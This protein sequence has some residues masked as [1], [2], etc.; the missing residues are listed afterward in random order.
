MNGTYTSSNSRKILPTTKAPSY[1]DWKELS[2][3]SRNITF[4]F[5]AKAREPRGEID[6]KNLL[7]VNDNAA[8]VW[9]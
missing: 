9:H 1:T 3:M 5:L 7:T 8:E 6:V 2:S 4:G